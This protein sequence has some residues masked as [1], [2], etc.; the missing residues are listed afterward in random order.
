MPA[1]NPECL[2]DIVKQ[3]LAGKLVIPEFQRS[4]V[5]RREDIEELLVSVFRGYFVGSFL[6]LDT[7]SSRPLFASRLVEGVAN[8][9]P[10]ADQMRHATLRLLLDGQQ[11]VT[12]LLYVL[13]RPQLPL[14][15]SKNPYDFFLKIRPA[16]SGDLED[17]VVGV[18]RVDR[19]GA[20]MADLVQRYEAIPFEWI[21]AE[22]RFNKWLYQ[23]QN[24]F[25]E[26]EIERLKLYLN[27]LH[28]FMVPVISLP[29]DTP[30][31][32]IVNIFERINS[33]GVTLS[34]FDLAVARLHLQGVHLKNLWADFAAEHADAADVV[35][36]ESILKLIALIRNHESKRS[37]LLDLIGSLS[38]ADF[39]SD[40]HDAIKY[41]VK[42][43]SRV[44]STNGYGACDK[45]WIPYTTLIVPMAVLMREID[46]L[47]KRKAERYGHLDRW[48]WASVFGRRYDQGVD[49]MSYRDVREMRAWF[50]T[51]TAPAWT[52]TVSTSSVDLDV[53][54]RRSAVY[55]GLM[56]L[57]VLSGAGDFI[58]GQPAS[59]AK[60]QDDHIFPKAR[61]GDKD[62]INCILNR[63][64]ISSNQVKG[65]KKPSSFLPLI[66]R[67][68]GGDA[69][70]LRAT[71]ASHLISTDAQAA[72]ERDDFSRFVA[73]R[74]RVFKTE[75]KSRLAPG[76]E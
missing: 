50:E 60:C 61:F 2:M 54:E 62:G 75:L 46:I 20:E 52:T 65:D 47:G 30:T 25:S 43:H 27:R 45:A 3:A 38:K 4:F 31:G 74:R 57:V 9:N 32:D 5:W 39:E 64:L 40:W 48:Y 8:A 44:R 67:E 72:L 13:S 36:P 53:D 56:C 6:M 12:S 15:G 29:E 76:S 42:A 34:M 73:A 21:G 14:K 37:S 7:P 70:A 58:T 24:L 23:E 26:G 1:A 69:L 18:S 66:L 49:T 11:R 59:L 51:G 68:H 55:R 28:R 19:R 16:L 63:T 10:D 71:L 41:L 35:K 22:S 17:A 33:T